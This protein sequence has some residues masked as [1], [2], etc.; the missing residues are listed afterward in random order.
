MKDQMKEFLQLSH[1][2]RPDVHKIGGCFVSEKLDGTRCLWD[3][4]IS[5]GMKTV[6][7]PWAGTLDPKTGMPKKKVKPIATGL[8][9]RSGNPI[10]VPDEF[11]DTLPPILLDGELWAG[12]GNFQLCRS[13]C[14]RDTPDPRFDK[15]MQF[16]VFSCPP[17]KAVFQTREIKN[18]NF[19][20]ILNFKEV[21]KWVKKFTD[22][23]ATVP[24]GATFEQELL[25]MQDI[26][27]C[28]NDH[29]YVLK[30]TLLPKDDDEAKD[31][32]SRLL[33][34]FLD[35]GAEGLIIR[36]PSNVWTPKRTYDC[37]KYKPWQDAEATVVG[38]T[39]G[40]KTDKGSKLLGLIG[41]II[42]EYNGK[43]LELS[44]LKNVEREFE[45][46]K[47]SAHA[48]THPGVDMPSYFQGKHFKKGDI[49]TFKYR[50]LSDDGIP[51]EGRYFR[52][53]D[54]E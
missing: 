19:I 47:Q 37:L 27:H 25:H 10:I 17:L 2:Y 30:Q 53:R 12:R 1:V 31:A 50:E 13:I 22:G 26:E 23:L 20:K 14:G 35:A 45:N 29:V 16:V 3:G 34:E 9:S 38:F 41:A 5:R 24:T 52:K 33:D 32:V 15:N 43:R 48:T 42:V 7:V 36:K 39:S 44:G 4:G 51:K 11:L 21:R 46:V 6:D 40:R 28:W 8:W 49:I 18:P 54:I